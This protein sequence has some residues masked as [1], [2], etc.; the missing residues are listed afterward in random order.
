ML[1]R[2]R[3]HFRKRWSV[4]A[5]ADDERRP[6]MS[7]WKIDGRHLSFRH[8]SFIV[9]Q[10]FSYCSYIVLISFSHYFHIAAVSSPCKS[11]WGCRMLYENTTSRKIKE[12][13][14][15]KERKKGRKRR[16]EKELSPNPTIIKY[17]QLYKEQSL[18]DATL[19]RFACP[20]P[21]HHKPPLNRG[22]ST[23]GVWKS[24]LNIC[25]TYKKR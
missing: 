8:C 10:L 23:K 24:I 2:R 4:G 3:R 5:T 11:Y 15:R 22:P 14:R 1:R 13:G 25:E 21:T 6:P 18:T 19:T 17:I 12:E 7:G 16:K 20:A 9:C